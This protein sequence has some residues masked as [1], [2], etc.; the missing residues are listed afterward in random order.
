MKTVVLDLQK[1]SE[2]EKSRCRANLLDMANPTHRSNWTK[3]GEDSL[4][5]QNF[6]L[7][8]SILKNVRLTDG[9]VSQKN[10]E[11]LYNSI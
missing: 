4:Y 3:V 5:K 1:P 2:L 9:F 10:L 7:L 8:I 11:R 6:L